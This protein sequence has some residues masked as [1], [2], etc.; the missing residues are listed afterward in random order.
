MGDLSRVPFQTP[1]CFGCRR[2]QPFLLYMVNRKKS[3][4]GPA[5]EPQVNPTLSG[6]MLGKALAEGGRP[7]SDP[8][9][10]GPCRRRQTSGPRRY[11]EGREQRSR[12]AQNPSI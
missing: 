12:Q 4:G 1:K 6:I 8:V 9:F 11:S 5:V 10:D 7:G 2:R 3:G